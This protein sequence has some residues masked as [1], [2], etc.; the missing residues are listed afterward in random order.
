MF[1]N[2][3]QE[4]ICTKTELMKYKYEQIHAMT[5]NQHFRAYIS[6]QM[7]ILKIL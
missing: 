7:K 6:A 1:K 4:L 3:R 2:S 5:A